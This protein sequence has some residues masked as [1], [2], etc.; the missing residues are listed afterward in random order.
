MNDGVN[1]HFHPPC[2]FLDFTSLHYNLFFDFSKW[3]T[4]ITHHRKQDAAMQERIRLKAE[5]KKKASG[6]KT[7]TDGI[8]GEQAKQSEYKKRSKEEQ[9]EALCEALGRGC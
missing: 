5:L 1:S 7:F 2:F 3:T 9:R 8:A 6:P 4:S